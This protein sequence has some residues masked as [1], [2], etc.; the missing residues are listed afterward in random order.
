MKS[1]I[2]I[3]GGSLNTA[4]LKEWL[5]TNKYNLI[6]AVDK[7]LE[8]LDLLNIEADYII[9]DFDSIDTNVLNKYNKNV[10]KLN[11]EKDFTDTHEGLKLEI[12]LECEKVD[13]VGSIGTRIDHV[14]ANINIL[15][16]PLEKNIKT[17]IIDENN[18]IFLINRSVKIKKDDNYKY[19]SIIPLTTTVEGITLKGFKYLLNNYILNL[20]Q[21]IG[22]SNEQQKEEATIELKKGILIVIFSKD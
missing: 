8:A 2:I 12:S 4:W 14:L 9:G 13:I 17:R 1:A 18:Q 11:P 6:I 19:L 10:I 22:V 3:S 15:K 20:G 16:E 7:G 21:S 5:N